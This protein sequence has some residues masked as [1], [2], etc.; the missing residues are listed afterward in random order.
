M[1]PTIC[2][3]R[4]DGTN[5]DRET[6][7]AF[8]LAGGE[9]HLVH[10]NQLRAGSVSLRNFGAL[11]I[12]G[13]FSYGDDIAAGAVLA[14]ELTSF[15]REEISAFVEAGKLVIGICNG[16][17]VLVRT[18]LLPTRQMGEQSLSL[19]TNDS[20]QFECRWVRLGVTPGS[21]C[22]FTEGLEGLTLE[23]P[24]AHA[25]GR[26]VAG[27]G[28]LRLIH[29]HRLAPLWYSYCNQSTA[30]YPHNP[31][32]SVDAVAGV[33]DTTGRVFGLMPHPERFVAPTQ[34]P[35]WRQAKFGKPHGLYIFENAVK[36]V[37][38]V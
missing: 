13:G 33:C 19:A 34:H 9:P 27:D 28:S 4:T 2:V 21:P 20:D 18:G 11:A 24:V 23:L 7:Y 22:V 14:N 30:E 12:P 16:F 29:R 8:R 5:C 38:A 37:K 3:L 31:N 6:A 15:L 35:N 26:F 32:G 17:Q 25:E 10:V 36:H 1:R